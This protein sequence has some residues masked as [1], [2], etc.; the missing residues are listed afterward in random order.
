MKWVVNTV[1]HGWKEKFVTVN[2]LNGGYS[3]FAT[4]SYQF[5]LLK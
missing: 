1:S 5:R 3:K 2:Y 4:R